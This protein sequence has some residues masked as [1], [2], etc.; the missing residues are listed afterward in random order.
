MR[1]S[2]KAPNRQ[3][4]LTV[5]QLNQTTSR[6]RRGLFAFMA[7][8][9]VVASMSGTAYAVSVGSHSEKATKVTTASTPRKWPATAAQ[10]AI[11]QEAIAARNRAIWP[12]AV[13]MAAID[14]LNA[15]LWY[16]HFT[17][18]PRYTGSG[19]QPSSH[20]R[21][22]DG[23]CTTLESCRTCVTNAES[24]HAGLYDARNPSG[25]GGRYQVMPR[26]WGNFGGY[27]NAAD[28]PPEVQDQWF[29]AAH[30]QYHGTSQWHQLYTDGC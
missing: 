9:L 5:T 17:P 30:S 19:R 29:A 18:K 6:R 26:T 23:G 16:A 1:R 14:R 20:A 13:R 22:G 2:S 12:T 24:V 4:P 25:A 11:Q 10:V 7:G 15:A 27:A 21:G 28:A 3:H 8:L